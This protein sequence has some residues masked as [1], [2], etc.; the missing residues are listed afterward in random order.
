M[1]DR[2]WA[3]SDMLTTEQLFEYPCPAGYCQCKVSSI[4]GDNACVYNYDSGDPDQ[5]CSCKRTGK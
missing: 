5:Q 4:A 2:L 1:Q 3:T